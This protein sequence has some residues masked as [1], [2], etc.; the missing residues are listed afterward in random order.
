MLGGLAAVVPFGRGHHHRHLRGWLASVQLDEGSLPL[1]SGS[2]PEQSDTEVGVEG[3]GLQLWVGLTQQFIFIR[4]IYTGGQ[5]FLP[6]RVM[7]G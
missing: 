7:C 4:Y 3:R 5:E 1:G 2:D 6:C